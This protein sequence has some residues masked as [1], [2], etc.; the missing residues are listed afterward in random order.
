MI[1]DTAKNSY[2]LNVS[3]DILFPV[4]DG[5]LLERGVAATVTEMESV[6]EEEN[7]DDVTPT[8]GQPSS[9]VSKVVFLYPSDPLQDIIRACPRLTIQINE[10]M[11]GTD[12]ADSGEFEDRKIIPSNRYFVSAETSRSFA[13]SLT[14][15]RQRLQGP[16]HTD[17]AGP[18]VPRAAVGTGGK[19]NRRKTSSVCFARASGGTEV[20][21][22]ERSVQL[23]EA[24]TSLTKGNDVEITAKER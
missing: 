20:V 19:G 23:I 5:K 12:V 10:S 13:K 17:D 4:S 6:Q 24:P 8:P 9:S 7:V 3:S 21:H 15:I 22:V 18:V 11:S 2:P 14:A 1:F 16:E